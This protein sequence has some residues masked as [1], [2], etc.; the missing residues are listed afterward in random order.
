M[1]L[2]VIDCEK[3]IHA[4]AVI[5]EVIYVNNDRYSLLLQLLYELRNNLKEV[6]YDAYICDLE[7]GSV[8]VLIKTSK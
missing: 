6:P 7:D 2:S 4:L 8:C 3:L 5:P 1:R